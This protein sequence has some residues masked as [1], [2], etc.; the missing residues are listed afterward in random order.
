MCLYRNRCA[1]Y[2]FMR[3]ANLRRGYLWPSILYRSSRAI[4]A[5]LLA[6]AAS[7][8][9]PAIKVAQAVFG[10]IEEDAVQLHH[11]IVRKI[12]EPDAK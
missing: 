12:V 10:D 2:R 3:G 5:T 1:N 7:G 4:A 9:V 6:E 8:D 11:T